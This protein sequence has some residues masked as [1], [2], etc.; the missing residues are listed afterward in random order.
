MVDVL[1]SRNIQTVPEC[2]S[3]VG[4]V[5]MCNE[6]RGKCGLERIERDIRIE[7]DVGG[8]GESK[9]GERGVIDFQQLD[10]FEVLNEI[11]K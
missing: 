5:E 2:G 4:Y 1:T 8:A 9:E 3:A 11:E 7:V 6:V 10:I